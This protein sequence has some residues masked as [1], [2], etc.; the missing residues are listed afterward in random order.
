M[1]SPVAPP[2]ILVV[3][4]APAMVEEL[5]PR[6]RAAW[7]MRETIAVFV[8]DLMTQW[9]RIQIVG[10]HSARWRTEHTG[11][12]AAWGAPQVTVGAGNYLPE[13]VARY[14]LAPWAE[15][16]AGSR[17][18]IGTCAPDTLTVVVLDGPAGLTQRAPL[19]LV[20]GATEAHEALT[21]FLKGQGQCPAVDKLQR[22]GVIE[23]EL[24]G[25]LAGVAEGAHMQL[26]DSDATDGVGRY[27]AFI[28][29]KGVG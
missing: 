23:P 22:A 28:L 11:S 29:P 1:S 16:I 24:W 15:K 19:A 17:A 26:I 7:R 6:D 10:S 20:E 14:L 13:L 4:G 5:A 25:E 2:A 18:Q 3:P 9:S 27:L 21:A 12:F 8:R